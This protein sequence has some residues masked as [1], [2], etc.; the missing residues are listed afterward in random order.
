MGQ[1]FTGVTE[2]PRWQG[3][4]PVRLTIGGNHNVSFSARYRDALN[5]DIRDLTPDDLVGWEHDSGQWST[6][7][8]YNYGFSNGASVAFAISNL[9]VTDPPNQDGQRFNR[10]ARSY[11]LQYRHTFEQ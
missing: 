10:R 2:M 11:N 8:N 5:R 3:T 9:T 4:F 6:A 7:V 1:G